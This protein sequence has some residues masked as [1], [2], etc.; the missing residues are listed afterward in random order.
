MSTQKAVSAKSI[1]NNGGSVVNGG[2]DFDYHSVLTNRRTTANTNLGVF[3]STVVQGTGVATSTSS[4]YFAE[5]NEVLAKRVKSSNTNNVLL[6]G[7][8]DPVRR[9]SINRMEAVRTTLWSTAYRANKFSLYHGRFV[10]GYP[11]VS[12]D[13]AIVVSGGVYQDKAADPTRSAPGKLVYRTGAKV[14][15][16]SNYSAKNS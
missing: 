6:S 14:P 10:S 12:V 11:E 9:R 3:G 5:V 8:A 15:V 16:A 13:D 7:A 2:T 4:P 1:V